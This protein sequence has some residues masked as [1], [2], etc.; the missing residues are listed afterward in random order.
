V[1]EKR[2][3]L[4]LTPFPFATL[5]PLISC[6]TRRPRESKS[7]TCLAGDD[8]SSRTA[9]MRRT[10]LSEVLTWL[11]DRPFVHETLFSCISCDLEFSFHDERIIQYEH[12]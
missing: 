11:Q 5:N 4:G 3:S 10:D 8:I 6:G 12:A 7:V 9:Y 2:R 1:G